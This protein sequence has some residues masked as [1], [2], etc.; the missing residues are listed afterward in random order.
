MTYFLVN[1]RFPAEFTARLAL[2][3][4]VLHIPEF[5]ALDFPV[6][7]HP[8]M[9]A[10][11]V[12]GKLFIHGENAALAELL[13]TRGIPFSPVS[14]KAGKS[15]PEDVSLNLFTAGGFLFANTKYASRDVLAFAESH[16]FSSACVKQGYAKCSSM[17]IGDAVVTADKAIYRAATMRGI[18]A[19]LISPGFVGI[20]KYDTGFIGGASG[21]LAKGKTAVFGDILS[22][23]DG[24]KI[25]AFAQN[26]GEEII[27]FGNG[28]LFDYGGIVRIEN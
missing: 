11:N 4:T 13:Q 15:Y 18:D 1:P 25:L 6:N 8:D 26:H 7:A 20:E 14:D 27:S 16:G 5:S 28:A 3:G 10:V 19:L 23:P 12:C 22:H 2:Y 9:Q 21:T 17:L 24:E